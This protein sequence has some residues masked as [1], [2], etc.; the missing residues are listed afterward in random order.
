MASS[1]AASSP[2]PVITTTLLCG[3]RRTTSESRRIPSLVPLGSGGSPRS[4]VTTAGCRSSKRR[5]AALP[6]AASVTSKSPANAQ[7]SWVAIA[8]SS[9]TMRRWGRVTAL[10]LSI[11]SRRGR[12]EL[13]AHGRA[14]AFLAHDVDGGAVRGQ[15]RLHLVEADAEPVPLG[16]LER[17]EEPRRQQVGPNPPP[18]VR[19]LER[20]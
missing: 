4:S 20:P 19:D 9:S 12:R 2:L 17:R 8:S 1:A 13:D 10:V 18:L 6:S 3:A 16:R 11:G 5:T 7:R 14:L 15:D